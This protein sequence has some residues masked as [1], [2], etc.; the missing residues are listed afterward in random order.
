M[1]SGSSGTSSP[2]KSKV[3]GEVVSSRL[4]CL[5]VCVCVITYKKEKK[6]RTSIFLCF[7][8]VSIYRKTSLIP[9]VAYMMMRLFC[10]Y[11]LA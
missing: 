4:T 9:R 6:K 1:S 5:C 10:H 2:Y 8:Y 3:E 7:V 11:M